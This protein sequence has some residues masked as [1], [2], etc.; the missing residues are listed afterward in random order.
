MVDFLLPNSTRF[1]H[2][3]LDDGSRGSH[4]KWIAGYI[5]SQKIDSITKRDVE[6]NYPK[7][8]KKPKEIKN[9]METLYQSGWVA[10]GKQKK[11]GEVIGWKVNPKV[12]IQFT[13]K[14]KEEATRRAEEREKIQEAVRLFQGSTK[15]E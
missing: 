12:H 1:Y 3:T 11:N 2:D 10:P 4:A 9:T 14:A 5:L 15:G 8:R 13:E 6:I 7:L